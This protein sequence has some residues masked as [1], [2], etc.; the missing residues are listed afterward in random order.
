MAT[1]SEAFQAAVAHHSAG[2]L[3]LA[4]EI[5]RR[6]LTVEP[7]HPGALQLTGVIAHQVGRHAVAVEC[8]S[9]ALALDP[10]NANGHH[11]LGEAYRALGKMDEARACY[12]R[13]LQIA[14]NVAE[15]HNGLG[16]V[17]QHDKQLAEALASYQRAIEIN[18]GYAEAHNNLGNALRSLGR[19]DESVAAYLRSLALKPDTAMTHSNLAVAMQELGRYDQAVAECHR[20]LELQPGFV[21]AHCNLAVALQKQGKLDEA[22]T[23]LRR[24]LE[25]RP[26][27]APGYTNLGDALKDQG[28]LD[29]AL[30]CDRR[31]LEIAPDYPECHSNLLYT[32]HYCPD[33]D[34]RAIC[35]EHR[36][37]NERHAAALG[38]L[39]E[40]H[41]N[42][43][44]PERRL[45]VGYVSPDFRSHPQCFFTFPLFSSHD[46]RNFEIYGYADV[47]RPDDTTARLRA[48]CDVWRD[49]TGQTDAEI[50]QLVRRDAIDILVDLSMHMA[51]NHLLAFARKPAPVQVTWLAYQG[52]TGLETIDYRLTDPYIDPPGTHDDDYVEQSVR[53]ADSFWCYDPLAD[54]PAIGPLP[55]HANGCVTFGCLNNFCKVNVPLLKLWAKVLCGVDGSRLMV[56]TKEG[57]HR[58]WLLDVL[59]GEDVGRDRVTM[60]SLRSRARYLELYQGVDIG[61]DTLPYNGQTTTFDALWMGVPVV[62]MV[63]QTACSRAGLSIMTNLGMPELAADAPQQFVDVAVRLARDLPR[64]ANLRAT[65]RQRLQGSLLMDSPRF[66]RSVEAAYRTMWRRWCAG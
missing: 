8:I 19:L 45:R 13:A 48:C 27:Y 2:R 15:T 61:L 65:L 11:N 3:E 32:L 35:E 40:P 18:P 55:A 41:G 20:A 16:L 54:G 64:L 21:E 50:A 56:L 52:T 49:I 7:N 38:R 43:R 39:V 57:S 23:H 12:L 5:Y 4:E 46:R 33:W 60:V 63:G 58:Q 10:G 22:V 26:D 36:R 42:D 17:Q 6:I 9:R 59:E 44:S 1:L 24:A 66:A 53:L 51:H 30:A 14:P 37:W 34:S 28:R 62:T 47:P 31:A 29:E 25:L